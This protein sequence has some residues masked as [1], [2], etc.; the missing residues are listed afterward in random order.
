MGKSLS[1]LNF[2]QGQKKDVTDLYN[3]LVEYKE[4]DLA[5]CDFPKI[6]TQKLLHFIN[7]LLQK[8]KVICIKNL[9]NEELIGTCMYNKSEYWFSKKEAIV[10]QMI[11]IKKEFRSFSLTKKIIDTVK[12]EFN[13]M[14]ILLSITSGLGIDP[15]FYKLGFE[16]MGSNWRLI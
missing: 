9:D 11:Y 2:Y 5:D 10:I 6:D 1:S 4:T 16:N 15:V 7:T 3:L 14:H 13:D 12:N 8:G